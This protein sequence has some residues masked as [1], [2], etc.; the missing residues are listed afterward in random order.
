M[1]DR[2]LRVARTSN[3][4]VIVMKQLFVELEAGPDSWMKSSAQRKERL[5]AS[6]SQV[7][8]NPFPNSS[9]ENGSVAHIVREAV[10]IVK[11]QLIPERLR[12]TQLEPGELKAESRA[13]Q[14]GALRFTRHDFSLGIKAEAGPP[15]GLKSIG[16]VAD[17]WTSAHWFGTPVGCND[18][19]VS[20]GTVDLVTTGASSFYCLTF[21]PNWLVNQ[22][23]E[24]EP[25]RAS[26]K[27]GDAQLNHD[28]HSARRLR[29]Y[30]AAVLD[31]FEDTGNV[32]VLEHN[33]GRIV[34]PLLARSFE[35]QPNGDSSRSVARRVAAVRF[36]E[37]YVRQNVD[38]NPTLYDLS[39]IS[40]LRVRSL[41]NAFQ[42]VTGMSPMAYL[43]RRRLQSVRQTLLLSDKSRTRIIDVAANWGFWHM[44]HFASDY[45]A[46]FGESPSETLRKS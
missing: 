25:L 37:E 24:A 11:E 15:D 27:P 33:I 12:W 17:E 36:C 8:L 4:L 29:L 45:R 42:A 28:A 19:A 13:V 41:I 5:R 18:V 23:P 39:K 1:G 22:F 43:K 16:V 32:G 40:G 46:M 44:G 30:T 31:P 20:R 38:S 21:D 14:A 3:E 6:P 34:L 35:E 26:M 2:V 7:L 10:S 9:P